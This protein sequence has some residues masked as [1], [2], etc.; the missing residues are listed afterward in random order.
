MPRKYIG[1]AAIG[2]AFFQNEGIV[3]GH[4]WKKTCR[5]TNP[6]EYCSP[7]RLSSRIGMKRVVA[8]DRRCSLTSTCLWG[9]TTRLVI[10]AYAC[11]KCIQIHLFWCRN[12]N[13]WFWSQVV[14]LGVYANGDITGLVA[15]HYPLSIALPFQER[16]FLAYLP[17][18]QFAGL[19]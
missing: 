18:I 13:G 16:H 3:S 1:G 7:L 12:Y 17:S 11:D 9:R 2:L 6:T 4:W 15:I 8:I 14:I 10:R 5:A 19:Q